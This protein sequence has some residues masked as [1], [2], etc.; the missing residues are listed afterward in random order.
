MCADLS[1]ID[2]R[3]TKKADNRMKIIE[4]THERL[5]IVERP[6]GLAGMLTVFSVVLIIGSVTHWAE[7]EWFVRALMVSWAVGLPLA[8]HFFVH[9]VRADFNRLTGRID[10]ARR[11]PFYARRDVYPLRH[12][13]RARADERKDDGVS[14]RLVFMFDEAMLDEMEPGLRARLERKRRRGFREVGPGDVPFTSYYSSAIN[15][16]DAAAKINA[17]ADAAA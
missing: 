6:W 15:A 5:C 10:I 13:K 14:Y 3:K 16:H 2:R 9:W 11:G 12:F 4:N 1:A 7:M 8:L 17:W